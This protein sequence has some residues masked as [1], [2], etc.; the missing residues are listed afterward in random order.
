[1]VKQDTLYGEDLPD[2][3]PMRHLLPPAL[4]LSHLLDPYLGCPELCPDYRQDIPPRLLP[5][6]EEQPQDLS[7]RVTNAVRR[8]PE[9]AKSSNQLLAASDVWHAENGSR[10]DKVALA[11]MRSLGLTDEELQRLP[12]RVLNGMVGALGLGTSALWGL[13]RRRR[14]LK[15]RGYAAASRDRRQLQIFALE[16][17]KMT[18]ASSNTELRRKVDSLALEVEE[19]SKKHRDLLKW[20]EDREMKLPEELR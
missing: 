3:R 7:L 17:R 14:S 16:K 20:A 18:L 9:S 4:L 13:R 11:C 10:E 12:V 6:E 2:P 15:N 1:M 8:P 5:I 19:L